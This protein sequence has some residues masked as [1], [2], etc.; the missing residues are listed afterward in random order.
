MCDRK[1]RHA[2]A[3][4]CPHHHR[5]QRNDGQK[6]Q[7]FPQPSLVHVVSLNVQ[8]H[9]QKP[10]CHSR[11]TCSEDDNAVYGQMGSGG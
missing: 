9:H 10:C 7:Y 6:L 8:I 1:L 5:N 4:D 2:V 3:V 11:R